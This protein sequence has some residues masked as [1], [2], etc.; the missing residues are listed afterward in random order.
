MHPKWNIGP[1]DYRNQGEGYGCILDGV[2]VPD[3]VALREF[4][5]TLGH[6]GVDE[7][8]NPVYRLFLR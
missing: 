4:A 6:P 3:A 5:E 1:F 8:E 2:Q 7:T